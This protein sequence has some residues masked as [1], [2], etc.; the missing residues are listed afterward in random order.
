[1][2]VLSKFSPKQNIFQYNDNQV[3]A[4]MEVTT[5]RHMLLHIKYTTVLGLSVHILIF[6]RT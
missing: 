4:R 6:Q 3:N 1:M 5:K 2:E